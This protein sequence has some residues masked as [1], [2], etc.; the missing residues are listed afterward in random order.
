M[1]TGAKI[2]KKKL[3]LINLFQFKIIAII[4]IAVVVVVVG[5]RVQRVSLTENLD[6]CTAQWL[7]AFIFLQREHQ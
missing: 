2:M 4:I 1:M 6:Y 7:A 3:F 5:N